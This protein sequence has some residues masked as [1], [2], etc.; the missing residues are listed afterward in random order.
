VPSE[1]R[2]PLNQQKTAHFDFLT[3]EELK[4]LDEA[5]RFI[6]LTI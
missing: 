2:A 4:A 5:T 6:L 3:D 1:Q